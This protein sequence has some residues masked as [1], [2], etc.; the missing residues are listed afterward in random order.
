M[1]AVKYVTQKTQSP[2]PVREVIN[3]STELLTIHIT[4]LSETDETREEL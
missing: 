3:I 2:G 1:N 4:L